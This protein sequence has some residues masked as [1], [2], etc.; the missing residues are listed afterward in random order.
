MTPRLEL[1]AGFRFESTNGWNEAHGRASNYDFT[2][3]V[4]NTNPTIGGSALSDNR[5]KFLPEP[6]IG[7]AYDVFGNGKTALRGSFGVHRALL[8]TL[9]YRL[10]QTAPYNTTLSFSNT[11]VTSCRVSASD[12]NRCGQISPSNVQR[13]CYT[14]GAGMDFKDRAGDCPAYDAHHGIRGL[15]WI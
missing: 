15:A 5:A 9:D 3:G 2:D 10:D 7:L 8:D 6:R 13:N 1:R 14:H 11:T 4:I 12:G